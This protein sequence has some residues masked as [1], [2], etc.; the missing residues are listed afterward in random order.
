MY[1]FF[2]TSM[3]G[4]ETNEI[5]SI[6]IYLNMFIIPSSSLICARKMG[7][8]ILQMVAANR[9]LVVIKSVN[10]ASTQ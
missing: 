3:Q 6:H 10:L 7:G 1:T 8:F 5:L 2:V 9:C 4:I